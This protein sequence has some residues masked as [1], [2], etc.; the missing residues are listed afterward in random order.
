MYERDRGIHAEMVVEF[1]MSIVM[2]ALFFLP[3]LNIF[4]QPISGAK[5]FPTLLEVSRYSQYSWVAYL[6][7]LLYLIPL[8]AF[9]CVIYFLAQNRQGMHRNFISLCTLTIIEMIIL[10][11]LGAYAFS[12]FNEYGRAISAM[13]SSM[14]ASFWI[15]F[16]LS[17]IGLIVAGAA[18]QSY[19]RPAPYQPYAPPAPYIPTAPY[20]PPQAPPAAPY[21]PPQPEVRQT[22]P[23]TFSLSVLEGEYKGAVY[24]IPESGLVI[25]SDPIKAVLVIPVEGI[26]AKHC[27]VTYNSNRS[28]LAVTDYS[29]EG[30]YIDKVNRLVQGPA[31]NIYPGQTLHLGA[32]QVFKVN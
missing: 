4:Y 17:V 28:G 18:G 24:Q 13:V 26:S 27:L 15:L 19:S 2:G 11:L 16:A 30:T 23:K 7:L 10:V 25:G 29:T 5:I 21:A 8:L 32:V 22:A 14:G 20:T 31:Y 3:W 9:I 1:V 12:G 6:F